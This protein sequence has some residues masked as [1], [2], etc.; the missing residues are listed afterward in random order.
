MNI[1][2][3]LRTGVDV[4]ISHIHIWLCNIYLKQDLTL[5]YKSIVDMK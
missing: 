5:N 2:N 4:S 3:V 1:M